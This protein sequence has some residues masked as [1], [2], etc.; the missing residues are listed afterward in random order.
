M[1]YERVKGKRII[2]RKKLERK[3]YLK[4]HSNCLFSDATG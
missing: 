4:T 1:Q 3:L 2:I